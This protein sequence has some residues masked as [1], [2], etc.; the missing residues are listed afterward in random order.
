[1]TYAKNLYPRI[2]TH[3]QQIELK[4]IIFNTLDFCGSTITAVNDYALENGINLEG[5]NGFQMDQFV[6]HCYQEYNDWN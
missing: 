1:M 4:E 6:C 2:L 5:E 3:E